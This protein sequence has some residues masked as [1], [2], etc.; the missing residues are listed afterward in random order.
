MGVVTVGVHLGQDRTAPALCVVQLNPRQVDYETIDHY[1]TR[2]LAALPAGSTYPEI[3]E[4]LGKVLDGIHFQIRTSA[5]VFVNLTGLGQPVLDLLLESAQRAAAVRGVYFTHGDRLDGSYDEILLGKA[6]LVSRLQVLLQAGRLH[7][8]RT[9]EAEVLARE[10]QDFEIR[11]SED[12]NQRYGAFPVG[13]RDE[14]VTALGLALHEPP[15]RA[16]VIDLGLL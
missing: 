15:S 4:R 13:S 7:L 2:Y 5:Q 1:E 3:A 16:S 6:R 10:L 8:P 9:N 14:L 12:A 11:V